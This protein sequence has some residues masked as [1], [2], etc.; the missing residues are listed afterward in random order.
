MTDRL[1]LSTLALACALAVLPA[2][3]QAPRAPGNLSLP[4]GTGAA[5]SNRTADFI[6]ALVNSEPVTNHDVRQRLRQ[7]EQNIAQRGIANAPPREE[8]VRQ[9]LE[10]LINERAQ[11]QFAAESGLR[12]SDSDLDLAE[13][14]VAAQNQLGRDEFRR[15]LAAEGI[16]AN[17]FRNE[18]RQQ[19]LLQRV[20]EREVDS[21]VRVSDADVD[22]YIRE[23]QGGADLASLELNLSHVLVSVPENAGEAQVA[24]RQA[25]AQRVAERAR[26]GEDFAT[27]AREFSDAP[28]RSNGGQFGWRT[29]SRLPDLFV[30]A[31]RALS[32]GEVAGPLRSLAGFHVLRVNDKRGAGLPAMNVTQTRASHILLRPGPQLSEEAA[33]ARLREF[34]QR[35]V[36][37]QAGF[38]ALAREHS[39]DGSAAAG[40]TLGWAAPGLFV[41]EFEQAMNRLQPGELSEP[42]V[43]R[44]GVHLIR[45]DERRSVP[46]DERQRRE[47]IRAVVREQKLEEALALWARDV[48]AR[49][50]VEVREDPQP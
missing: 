46:L 34:R 3:A 39:Q 40:G 31:T 11:L 1:L 9:V 50:Y 42:V 17:R 22:D 21:R 35:I 28:E 7:V 23:Q 12:V 45:V 32:P 24:E 10:Q 29:A 14:N 38:E 13:Q 41:P 43:S 20:R 44:F 47:R 48:R 33:Q 16:D 18:L 30:N 37:G 6:V 27:L 2:N 19:I 26:A 15:R 49:A 4:P 8:L 5:A 25:R 36:A